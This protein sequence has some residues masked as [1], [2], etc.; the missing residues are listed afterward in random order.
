MVKKVALLSP[1]R[2]ERVVAPLERHKEGLKPDVSSYSK[3]RMRY[4]LQSEWDLKNRSFSEAVEDKRLWTFCKEFM[5]SADLGLVAYGPIG[6]S[7]HRDDSY[8]DWKGV[9]INLGELEAWYYDCQYPDYR[10][11][12]YTN[13]P[14]PQLLE[15]KPGQVFYFNTK[16]PHAA[17]KPAANRWAI[18]LWRVNKKYR[19]KFQLQ[20][21]K[22]S[23]L[24]LPY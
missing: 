8:A 23:Q 14:N 18:F 19:E 10:W 1:E 7:P 13:E 12:K 22:T 5:P 2:M 17:V 24:R 9:G 3:G 4:W 11:T 20:T 21:G 16:N 6:I 15:M